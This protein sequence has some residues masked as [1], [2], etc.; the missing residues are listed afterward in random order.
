MKYNFFSTLCNDADKHIDTTLSQLESGQITIKQA[1]ENLLK[2]E[3]CDENKKPY[4]PDADM[5]KETKY[6]FVENVSKITNTDEDDVW[7]VY[8]DVYTTFYEL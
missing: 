2:V 4:F 5:T 1:F 8:D 7:E 3:D 6:E